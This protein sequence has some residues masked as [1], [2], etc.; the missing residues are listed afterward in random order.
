VLHHGRE[1]RTLVDWVRTFHAVVA[2]FRNNLLAGSG[3]ILG[4]GL[5]LVVCTENL[6]RVDDEMESPKLVE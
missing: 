6:I 4:N 1:A 2:V 5:T 3:R